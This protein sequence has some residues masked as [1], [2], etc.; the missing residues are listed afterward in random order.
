MKN[1]TTLFLTVLFSFSMFANVSTSERE[2]LVKLYEK[3][4]GN[5]WKTKWDLSAS[6]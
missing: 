3:T 2:A 1:L 5:Q 6:A 4:N